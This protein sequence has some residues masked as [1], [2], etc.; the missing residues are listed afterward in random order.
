VEKD[1]F[2]IPLG[3]TND[4]VFMPKDCVVVELGGKM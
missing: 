2:S 3:K 4:G 1:K